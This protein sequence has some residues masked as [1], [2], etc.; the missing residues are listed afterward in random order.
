[1]LGAISEA[2]DM[3]LNREPF[4]AP[5]ALSLA[6]V[7]LGLKAQSG[8]LCVRLVHLLHVCKFGIHGSFSCGGLGLV[9][10]CSQTLIQQEKGG[11][12]RWWR[13]ND[14]ILPKHIILGLI[15]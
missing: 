15:F 9:S 7:F 3:R 1:L 8:Y 10:V 12:Y 4:C 6:L 2:E 11:F 14:L 13:N 5:G